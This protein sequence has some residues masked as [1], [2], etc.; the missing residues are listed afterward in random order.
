MQY[1]LTGY[2]YAALAP[3][4]RGKI[5][6]EIDVD[7]DGSFK[8][9]AISSC[10]EGKVKIEGKFVKRDGLTKLLFTEIGILEHETQ[11]ETK[12]Y[13][14]KRGSKNLRGTY[15]GHWDNGHRK[16]KVEISIF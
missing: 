1:Q 15:K 5:L 16:E 13:T 6:G 4:Y 2:Y 11:K 12:Y 8:D 14:K 9:K 3:G 7:K 10:S